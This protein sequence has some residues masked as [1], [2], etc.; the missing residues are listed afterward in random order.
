MASKT[1]TKDGGNFI[2]SSFMGQNTANNNPKNLQPGEPQ[3]SLNWITGWNPELKKA[4]NIQ[5]RTGSALLTKTRL[6]AGKVNALAVGQDVTGKQWLFFACGGQMYYFN[7]ATGD[8]AAV[9]SGTLSATEDMTMEFYQDL[10]GP[11]MYSGSPNTGIN[12]ISVAN[13]QLANGLANLQTVTNGSS[14]PTGGYFT[15]R[16]NFGWLWNYLNQTTKISYPDN[17]NQS[18]PDQV[19]AAD[20]SIGNAQGSTGVSGNGVLTAFSGTLFA[21][22]PLVF[23]VQIAAPINSV[24]ISSIVINNSLGGAFAVQINTSTPI[25]GS[26]SDGQYVCLQMVTN[27]NQFS[28]LI[29]TVSSVISNSQFYITFLNAPTL[30]NGTYN[31]PLGTIS[32][33]EL[34][35]DDSNGNL[36]SLL[37]STGTINYITGVFT[38]NTQTPVPNG[39]HIDSI[40]FSGI[41]GV[42]SFSAGFWQQYGGPI[43][44]V[45]FFSNQLYE[46]HTIN[47]WL[48]SLG[49]S[50]QS[51]ASGSQ[52]MYRQNMGAP[53]FRAAYEKGDGILFLDDTLQNNPHFRELSIS[54]FNNAVEP[55]DLSANLNLSLNDFSN[56]CVGSVGNYDFL[57]CKS[58]SNGVTQSYN[59]T[60]YLRNNLSGFWDKTDF[61]IAVMDSYNGTIV[62]GDTISQNVM[63]LFVN[64]D[65]DGSP[66][67]N[68]WISGLMNLNMGGLKRFYYFLIDIYIGISQTLNIY[69]QFDTGAFVLIATVNGTDP[70]VDRNDSVVIGQGLS[71]NNPVGGSGNGQIYGYRCRRQINWVSDL[72]EYMAVKFQCTKFGALQ[73]NE[74]GVMSIRQKPLRVQT[75]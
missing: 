43:E 9:A 17:L 59:D 24:A 29:A 69:A 26:L 63:E 1:A 32:L 25:S 14:Y 19:S 42:L 23:T 48:L 3:D 38:I 30:T 56:C 21:F 66:I 53:Y 34:F 27:Y 58:I 45:K 62:A 54:D 46:F 35:E 7:P 49:Y 71:G 16:Q 40:A 36:K 20:S 4:D 73:V 22:T 68:Q 31:A 50:T 64:V 65:D 11:Y 51:T 61:R 2:V 33:V 8:L 57:A 60:C 52:E 67:N 70:D 41:P 47:T 28:D 39:L 5:L 72:F 15:I 13:K 75:I 6:G 12:A 10:F 74:F 55:D 44:A 18:N 37:G